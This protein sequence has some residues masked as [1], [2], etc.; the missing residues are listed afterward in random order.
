[1]YKRI[2]LKDLSLAAHTDAFQRPE[3]HADGAAISKTDDFARDLVA[4]AAG[5]SDSRA[6]T[7][8]VHSAGDFHQQALNANDAAILPIVR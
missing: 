5:Y 1:M 8:G 7:D 4:G 6:N 2:A 3:R